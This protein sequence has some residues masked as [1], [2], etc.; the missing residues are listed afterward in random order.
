VSFNHGWLA[1]AV[2][3]TSTARVSELQAVQIKKPNVFLIILPF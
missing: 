1:L 3:S 2:S